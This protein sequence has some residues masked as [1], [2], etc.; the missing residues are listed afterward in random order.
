M[1]E[2]FRQFA[3]VKSVK[4][5]RDQMTG[6]SK[7]MAYVE[8]F[9]TEHAMHTFQQTLSG[10]IYLDSS[11]LKILFAKESFRLALL[12]KVSIIFIEENYLVIFSFLIFYYSI[13]Y[14]I[15]LLI[16]HSEKAIY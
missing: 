4:I 15:F 12:S 7:G 11:P 8:F 3:Q 10:Q 5:L 16:R 2:L 14:F 13:L 6:M 1:I 9:S